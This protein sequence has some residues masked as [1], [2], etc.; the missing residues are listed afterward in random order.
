MRCAVWI[1]PLA[2]GA[3]NTAATS[4]PLRVHGD[5]FHQPSVRGQGGV[6]EQFNH[7][8][9]AAFGHRLRTVHGTGT[10]RRFREVHGEVFAGAS[11][12][13]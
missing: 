10:G 3:G 8:G 4:E 1:L 2:T 7:V 5:G 11:R 13:R 12:L 9:H 6:S